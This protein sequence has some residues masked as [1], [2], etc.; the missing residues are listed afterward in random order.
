MSLFK[1]DIETHAE[2]ACVQT[3]FISKSEI[4]STASGMPSLRTDHSLENR[5]YTDIAI[6]SF[7]QIKLIKSACGAFWVEQ[8]IFYQ[9]VIA[10]T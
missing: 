2:K 7:K 5:K 8:V 6:I 1:K 4:Q 9:R 3:L 10:V